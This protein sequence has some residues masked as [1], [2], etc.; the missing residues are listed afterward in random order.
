[1]VEECRLKTNEVY[2]TPPSALATSSATPAEELPADL[3]KA[4]SFVQSFFLNLNF[5]AKKCVK[6]AI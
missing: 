1:M 5:L 2:C 6:N 4:N 3:L